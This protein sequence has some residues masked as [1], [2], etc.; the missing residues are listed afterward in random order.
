MPHNLSDEELHNVFIY[1]GAKSMEAEQKLR[2][3]IAE[4]ER[5]GR[6]DL[7]QKLRKEFRDAL[8]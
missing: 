6:H 8:E 1:Y 5:R 4:L 2:A 7:A 3:G